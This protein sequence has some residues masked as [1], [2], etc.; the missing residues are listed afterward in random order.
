MLT[1][2]IINRETGEEVFK[3]ESTS[4]LLTET[5]RGVYITEGDGSEHSWYLEDYSFTITNKPAGE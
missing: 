1:I 2:K 3:T 5:D 4:F